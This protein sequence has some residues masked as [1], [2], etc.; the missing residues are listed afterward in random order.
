MSCFFL[1]CL[2]ILSLFFVCF[3][4]LYHFYS[5]GVHTQYH[6]GVPQTRTEGRDG[7][8]VGGGR[9][10]FEKAGKVPRT[11][12]HNALSLGVGRTHEYDGTS[13]P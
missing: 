7:R 4:G 13:P 5:R 2:E 11:S 8:E 1:M 12:G 9:Q 3:C 10:N 6:A